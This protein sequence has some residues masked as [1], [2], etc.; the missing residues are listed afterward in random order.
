MVFGGGGTPSAIAEVIVQ[1]AFAACVLTWVWWAGGEAAH[2]LP[3][4]L[5]ALA[6]AIVALPLLQMV[7]LPSSMWTAMPGRALVQDALA[8]VGAGS[9]WHAVSIAPFATLAALLAMVPAVGTMLAVGMLERQDRRFLVLMVAVL[10]LAGTAL[11]VLQMASGPG[12]FRLYEITHAE[13]LTS[14]YANRNAAVDSLLIGSLALTTWF[15]GIA[16][17]RPVT[18][19]DAAIVLLLQLFLWTGIVL[20]GSR[21]GIAL[22][23][24]VLLLQVAILHAAG[25][26][27]G[28]AKGL[29]LGGGALLL[30]AAGALFVAD[31]TR[32]GAVLAR[33]DFGRD[34]RADLWQDTMTA[35][36]NFW[37]VGSGMGTFTRAFL[38]S[39]RLI[40]IDQ[41]FPNRAHNDYL[42]FALE[43]G[44]AGVIVL[45]FA[46]FVVTRLAMRAW[47][48][49]PAQ[50]PTVLFALGILMV[51]GLHSLVDYPLRTM[52]LACL[53]GMAA[54]LLGAI[55]REREPGRELDD[56]R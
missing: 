36:A 12:R 19:N 26:A 55:A 10:A 6:A 47:R 31:N 45:L 5:G 27:R 46:A 48:L 32:L 29:A 17:R 13:W 16:R 39:E 24:L 37:P 21:A 18:R 22:L 9:D 20:T 7:P 23:P 43:S 42:E 28:I 15:A 53:A 51:I 56:N 50:R 25:I 38:P 41:T 33:F 3:R 4:S 44:L 35:V 11:G 30:V 1:L 49:H 8:V 2:T 52:A 14:F 40:A 54:G 34:A